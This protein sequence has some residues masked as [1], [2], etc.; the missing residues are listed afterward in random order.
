MWKDVVGYEGEYQ[1]SDTGIVKSVRRHIENGSAN[2]MILMERELKQFLTPNGYLQV[3]LMH[4]GKR[5]VK[6]VHK[7]VAEAFL[8]K[9][10]DSLIVNH[11]D[12][13]KTNNIVDNLE[14]VTYAENNQHA[15]DTGLHNKGEKHYKSKLTTEDAK[16]IRKNGKFATYETIGN[17]YHVSRA[18]IRDVLL[19]RTWNSA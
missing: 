14:F 8:N 7:L 2:G 11:K 12:G 16:T 4:N 1:V 19:E 5:K 3:S 10:E 13:N 18:T 17:I 9:P 6:Y 15:Y